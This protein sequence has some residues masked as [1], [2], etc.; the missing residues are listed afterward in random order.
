MEGIDT[1]LWKDRKRIL[2]LPISFTRYQATQD[3]FF[4]IRGLLKTET[5]EVLLYRVLDI[6][7]VR[8]FFQKLLGVG[9]ITLYCADQSHATLEV[10]NIKK[11][12]AVRRFLSKAIEQE[13][14]S[15]GVRGREIVGAAGMMSDRDAACDHE[16]VDRD[17]DGIPD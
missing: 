12:E 13:R 6:K 1:V 10:K 4:L 16:F 15:K 5:D 8:S 9:T 17:G 3:R 11:P 2:G 7:L 14:A